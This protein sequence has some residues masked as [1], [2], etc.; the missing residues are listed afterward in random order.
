MTTTMNPNPNST[1]IDF[2]AAELFPRLVEELLG[3][4]QRVTLKDL[5]AQ[6]GMK[7]DDIRRSLVAHF[8]ARVMFVRGRNGGIRLA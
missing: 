7:S 6:Y 8:G 1:K 5:A 3:A 2:A 4:G